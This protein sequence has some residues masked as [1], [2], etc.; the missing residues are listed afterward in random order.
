MANNIITVNDEVTIQAIMKTITTDGSNNLNMLFLKQ[1]INNSDGTTT[2][3][4]QP[5][6]VPLTDD[7]AKAIMTIAASV[8]A[9]YEATQLAASTP[10]VTNPVTPITPEPN[11][12]SSN[13]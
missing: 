3:L 11:A 7:E 8:I 4:S 6:T 9:R 10:P 1:C 2:S 13:S 5:A 12:S